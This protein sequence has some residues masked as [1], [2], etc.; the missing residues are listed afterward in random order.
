MNTNVK[1]LNKIL[2]NRI[3]QHI[4]KIIHHDQVT[5]TP[6][7]QGWFNIP[8]PTN[9]IQH[10]NR[11]KDKNHMIFSI[12][13]EKVFDKIQHPILIKAL[14][15][16]GIGGMYFNIIKAI[17]DKPI[18]NIILGE[19]KL[20]PFPPKSTMRQ[21]CPLSPLLIWNSQTEQEDKNKK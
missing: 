19:E 15:K 6:E 5:F 7:M 4:K 16:L 2:A 3:Q 21:V 18:A 13:T 17:E 1:I 8:K 14:M 9:V 20:K 12:Y 11:R 10:M